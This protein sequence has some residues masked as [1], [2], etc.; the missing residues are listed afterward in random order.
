MLMAIKGILMHKLLFL[1]F[2]ILLNTICY[3][4]S[5]FDEIFDDAKKTVKEFNELLKQQHVL[6]VCRT[7]SAT[8][9][10]STQCITINQIFKNADWYKMSYLK[11]IWNI[12][13]MPMPADLTRSALFAQTKDLGAQ[14]GW[15]HERI[16]QE[17]DIL[18]DEYENSL[19]NN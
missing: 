4:A 11:K 14:M 6:V 10:D 19:E 8:V 12:K 9:K 3:S 15:T 16:L 7:P 1:L 13:N 5:S 17:A 18:F 2:T